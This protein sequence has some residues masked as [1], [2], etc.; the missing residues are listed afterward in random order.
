MNINH[1]IKNFIEPEV[2][3]KRLTAYSIIDAIMNAGEEY[4]A[5]VYH[6]NTLWNAGVALFTIDDGGGDHFH[7]L[8]SENGVVIKG[9]GHESDLSPYNYGDD[10]DY[11]AYGFYAHMPPALY[12]LLDDEALERGLVTFCAWR[13]AGDHEWQAARIDVADDWSDGSADFLDYFSERE[14]YVAWLGEYY[15]TEIDV[16]TVYDILAGDAVTEEMVAVLN[17]KADVYQV[18]EDIYDIKRAAVV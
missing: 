13:E 17:P 15:D 14:A 6:C 16:A 5:S 3:L 12:E 7:V 8:F 1:T 9:F 4:D 2:L 11:P 18:L 10:A